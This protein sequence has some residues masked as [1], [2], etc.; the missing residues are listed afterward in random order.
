MLSFIELLRQLLIYLDDL[1]D[2]VHHPSVET[3]CPLLCLYENRK[4][5]H[6][7]VQLPQRDFHQR[8]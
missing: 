3:Q 4:G 1:L 8:S 6:L 7:V 2:V 5:S